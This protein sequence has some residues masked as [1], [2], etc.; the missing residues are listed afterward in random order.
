MKNNNKN[1][2]KPKH[3]FDDGIDRNALGDDSKNN[4]F[5]ESV[6]QNKRL[7]TSK[8]RRLFPI[9]RTLVIA[10][11]VAIVLGAIGIWRTQRSVDTSALAAKYYQEAELP[12][13]M[14]GDAE[15][16]VDFQAGL[17]A[18]AVKEDL[19]MA[20]DIFEQV[21]NDDS[22]YAEAQYFLGHIT[23]EKEQFEAAEIAYGNAL[24]GEN[25]PNYI[26]KN[27]LTWNL[28]LARLGAGKDIEEELKNFLPTATAFD[29][30]ARELVDEFN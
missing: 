4:E 26:D 1:L 18:F 27:R 8:N 7:S 19:E 15:I 22:R 5:V 25:L 29:E 30:L 28:M 13:T 23:F 2:D 3:S 24:F 10:A 11:S 21:P 16:D 20:K 17:T 9:G 14:S 12:S 6:D